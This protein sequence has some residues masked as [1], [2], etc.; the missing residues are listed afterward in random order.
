M[1]LSRFYFLED[2]Y[3][4][5]ANAALGES[6]DVEAVIGVDLEEY[7]VV[8]EGW[9]DVLGF[10]TGT[11]VNTYCHQYYLLTL[12]QILWLQLDK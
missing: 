9:E 8:S 3:K 11:L 12:D 1:I 10:L 5:S 6:A 4:A 7:E 2:N